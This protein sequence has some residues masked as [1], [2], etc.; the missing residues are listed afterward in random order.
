MTAL[1]LAV[2]LVA[3]PLSRTANRPEG[4]VTAVYRV[5]LRDQVSGL[6]SERQM[7]ELAP[8]LSARLLELFEEARRY[9]AEYE[10]E[11]P[12]YK[13]PFA[14]GD[15][16]SSLF[17]GPS[18]FA[19]GPVE[20]LADGRTQVTVEFSRVDPAAEGGAIR[21]KDAVLLVR[22]KD[23]FVVDDVLFLGNWAFKSGDRLT[24]VL[25]ARE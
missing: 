11:N 1:G 20:T 17:E 23:R 9:Q 24:T 18:T 2:L 19:V 4:V 12:D 8:F 16:F 25:R 5:C 6:P 14:D 10:K 13:P 21:W 22:E 7:K 3:A 15:L